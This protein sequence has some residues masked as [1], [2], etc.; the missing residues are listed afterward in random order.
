MPQ[1]T[2][3]E[4]DH[5]VRLMTTFDPEATRRRMAMH[6]NGDR[7]VHYTSAEN[8]M[9]I[10]ASQTMWLRNTNCM[11]DYSEI[12]LGFGYLQQFFSDKSR[13]Q[14]F[15]TALDACYPG[16]GSDSISHVNQWMPEIRANTYIASVSEHDPTEDLYGRRS[17]WRAFGQAATARAAI[18]MN[19]PDPWAAEGLH[20]SLMPVEYY[21][22]HLAW[23]IHSGYEH[24]V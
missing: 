12:S 6:V 8:A 9:K 2:Q 11:S 19:V 18:V 21:T 13:L 4:R 20:V 3:Q 10:I 16:L 22:D 5:L 15:V 14:R 1:L 17:M 7:V 23:I 24:A